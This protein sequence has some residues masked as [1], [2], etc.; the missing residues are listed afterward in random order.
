VRRFRPRPLHSGRG[1]TWVGALLGYLNRGGLLYDLQ[2]TVRQLRQ[3]L[4]VDIPPRSVKGKPPCKRS[5]RRLTHRLTD[6]QV[7]ELV[8]AFEAGTA[9]RLELAE[10][11]GIGRTS[12][13]SLLRQ[14]RDGSH[15]MAWHE[16]NPLQL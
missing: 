3:A 9:T 1:L 10:R 5:T 7:L 15:V 12:V 8:A 2:E 16:H 6:E 13:A 14:W 11:Y 4:S